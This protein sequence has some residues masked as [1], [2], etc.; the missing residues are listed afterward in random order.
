LEQDGTETGW[1]ATLQSP[2]TAF[3]T[4]TF[5]AAGPGIGEIADAALEALREVYPDLEAEEAK[6]TIGG[7]PAIGYDVEIF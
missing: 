3:L 5:D 7:L 2:A 6:D 4:V 1:I